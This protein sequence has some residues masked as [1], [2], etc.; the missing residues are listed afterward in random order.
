MNV[1]MEA[2][3]FG[4]NDFTI[5]VDNGLLRISADQPVAGGSSFS[6]SFNLPSGTREEDVR[7]SYEGGMLILSIHRRPYSQG[8]SGKAIEVQ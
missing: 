3:G 2:P 7:A 4:K 6:R 5:R 1:Q 8:L